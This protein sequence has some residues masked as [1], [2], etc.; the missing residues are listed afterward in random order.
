MTSQIFAEV[1]GDPIDHSLSPLIHGFWLET[2]GIDAEYRRLKVSRADFPAYIAERRGKKDWRGS[3]VT[4]PLKLDAAAFADDTTDRAVAAGAANVLMMREGKL[5]AANTDV[6]AIAVLL[7]RLHQ[8]KAAMHSVTLLGN[9]GAA[10]AALVACKMVGL[11]AVRI[12]ARDMAEA[13]KLAVEFGLDVGPAPLTETI[14]SDG[15]IN[16]TPRGMAGRDCLNCDL[17]HMPAN[18]WVFDM[19]TDPPETPLLH[20][21]RARALAVATGLDMLIEQ[22]ASSFQLFFGVGPP[23]DRDKELWQR[24]KR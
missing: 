19:V 11:S 7:S 1:I 8:A 13:T 22:A 9:G 15:L 24:L 21:A 2:L 17:S 18:G 12:Q 5:V 23:R 10:R 4:M 6:G 3:N 14:V 16:A 20:A